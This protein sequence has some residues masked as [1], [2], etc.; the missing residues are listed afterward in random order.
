MKLKDLLQEKRRGNTPKLSPYEQLEKYKDDPDVYITFTERDKVGINPNYVFNTPLGVY[1]Y[2]LKDVW[3]DFNHESKQIYVPFAGS[4]PFIW[5]MRSTQPIQS[6]NDYTKDQLYKD[7]D[8]ILSLYS[9]KFGKREVMNDI[10]DY[11][12]NMDPLPF[13]AL[14]R[15]TRSLSTNWINSGKPAIAWNKILRQLG[16]NGIVD[17]GNSIIHQSEPTQAVFLHGASFKTIDK[18]YNKIDSVNA[19]KAAENAKRMIKHGKAI[20]RQLLDI[21][22]KHQTYAYSVGRALVN[23]EM[24]IPSEILATICKNPSNA[25]YIASTYIDIGKWN[26]I[27]PEIIKSVSKSRNYSLDLAGGLIYMKHGGRKGISIPEI[28]IKSISSHFDT[29]FRYAKRMLLYTKG[30][31][32]PDSII[33]AISTDVEYSYEISLSY[34]DNDFDVPSKI[35][36]SVAT[37][38]DKKLELKRHYNK[39]HE[40]IP[41][42]L[43]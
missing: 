37:N 3:K 12:S 29:A 38:L 10:N 28:L 4:R 18:I 5:V 30:D 15:T 25:Y 36:K 16:Y 34:L 42:E 11:K 35:L 23:A 31:P 9:K 43:T 21:L 14:W 22:T 32:I 33:D 13:L 17:H 41:K 40:P 1:A 7:Y 6:I 20:P 8:K 24:D 39:I 2:P 27:P 19:E 26:M